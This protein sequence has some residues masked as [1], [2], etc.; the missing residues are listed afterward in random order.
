MEAIQSVSFVV[1]VHIHNVRG[2]CIC[3]PASICQVKTNV[4]NVGIVGQLS[5]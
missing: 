5:S 4:D 1:K 3:I 2:A